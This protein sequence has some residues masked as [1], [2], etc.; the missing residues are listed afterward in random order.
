M[1]SEEINE[2]AAALCKAQAVMKGAEKDSQNDFVA[3][4]SPRKKN[5]GKYADL[6]AVWE[7]IR[8]PLTANGLC[9]VQTIDFDNEK[10]FLISMLLHTSGQYIKSRLPLVPDRPGC[11]EVGKSITY[12]RRYA[13]S[14]LVGISQYDDDGEEAMKV[15]RKAEEEKR[16]PKT[17]DL[18]QMSEVLEAPKENI[19]RY[20][21]HLVF[22]SSKPNSKGIVMKKTKEG[23]I[24]NVMSNEDLKRQF[25]QRMKEFY[26]KPENN[27]GSPND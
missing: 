17:F 3:E 25:W 22:E 5:A 20:I 8:E 16:A 4:K 9:V 19:E 1:Q 26:D 2:L 6:H 12:S 27:P 14:A 23:M 24:N 11:Q 18:M 21:D 7:A 15:Y 13:L 10:S